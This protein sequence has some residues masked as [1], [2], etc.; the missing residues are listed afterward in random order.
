MIPSLRDILNEI[1]VI[2]LGLKF[3][4]LIDSDKKYSEISKELDKLGYKWLSGEKLI[5]WQP[6]NEFYHI[7]P[8]YLTYDGNGDKRVKWDPTKDQIDEIKVLKPTPFPIKVDSD[9]QYDKVHNLLKNKGYIWSKDFPMDEYYVIVDSVMFDGYP[10]Y[11]I[12]REDKQLD[13][14]TQDEYDRE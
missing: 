13:W 7:Y 14:L 5:N 4:I 10:I 3:P 8:Y 11:I 6:N 1:K 9:E 2:K 12:E